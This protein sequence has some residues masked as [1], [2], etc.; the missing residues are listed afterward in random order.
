[1]LP[2]FRES[3][4]PGKSRVWERAAN[5]YKDEREGPYGLGSV[6]TASLYESW[7]PAG[8]NLAWGLMAGSHYSVL[9]TVLPTW[10]LCKNEIAR[11]SP[12]RNHRHPDNID[13][14]PIEAQPLPASL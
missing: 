4:T 12:P 10:T 6:R 8:P 2:V 3:L 5:G 9:S 14:C 7:G 11:L 13:L 1:M